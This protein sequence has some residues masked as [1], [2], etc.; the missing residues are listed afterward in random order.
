MATPFGGFGGSPRAAAPAKTADPEP[1][2]DFPDLHTTA[3]AAE[4]GRPTFNRHATGW[5]SAGPPPTLPKVSL[6]AM[7]IPESDDL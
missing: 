2:P 4:P 5:V 7:L 3:A 1:L 6:Q